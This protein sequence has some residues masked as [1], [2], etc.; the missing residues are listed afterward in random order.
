[1]E[2]EMNEKKKTKSITKKAKKIRSIVMMSL[3]CVLMLSAATYAW[4]TLSKTA[5]V[6]N[7]TMTVGE[8]TGLQ[9][10]PNK[11]TSTNPEAGDYSGVLTFGDSDPNAT[12]RQAGTTYGASGEYRIT[13]QL[14]PATTTDGK[15]F[16]APVYDDDSKVKMVTATTDKLDNSI[17]STSKTGYYY[18]TEFYLKSLGKDTTVTLRKATTSS[19]AVLSNNGVY[20][21]GETGTYVLDKA[22]DN[23]SNKQ[24]NV[25]SAAIR[26]SLTSDNT[27]I[28]YEPNSDNAA[29]GTAAIDNSSATAVT[30][31]S[32]QKMDG[33]FDGTQS[34][35]IAL[36]KDADTL[37][38]MRI[39]VE[40]TD[41]QC[42]NEINLKNIIAQL[43]FEEVTTN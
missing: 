43:Q 17:N 41:D 9:I 1:M 19:G 16:S 5:K 40:G 28:V 8:A 23:Q 7:L 18:E 2:K 3:L 39:W 12:G 10:A 36:T 11:G 26:I 27:T 38:T 29:S 22:A 15:N 13:G 30:T 14:L 33:T 34:A 37:I 4:F 42:V 25:G 31:T 20:A 35:T 6:T 21:G 24:S 32:K